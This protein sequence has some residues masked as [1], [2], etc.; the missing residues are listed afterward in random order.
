MLWDGREAGP[1]VIEAEKHQL[2][3]WRSIG[4]ATPLQRS[5]LVHRWQQAVE[6]KQS[7]TPSHLLR[8]R[9]GIGANVIRPV[10]PRAGEGQHRR[11]AAFRFAAIAARSASTALGNSL[12]SGTASVGMYWVN[13]LA[14]SPDL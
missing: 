10:Q 11:Q 7:R 2:G 13:R 1:P 4:E 12:A 8:Q 6:R 5:R 9:L 3:F 14:R